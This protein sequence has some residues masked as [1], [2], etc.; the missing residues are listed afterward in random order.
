M[1]LKL[2]YIG[3]TT[4]NDLYENDIYGKGE[5]S[6]RY[7]KW[8]F[9]T[10]MKGWKNY[11][12]SCG[13]QVS[14]QYSSAAVATQSKVRTHGSDCCSLGMLK[15]RGSFPNTNQKKRK[16]PF[17]LQVLP[18]TSWNTVASRFST[19]HSAEIKTSCL[20]IV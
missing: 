11:F 3:H 5:K 20:C 13:Q 18:L 9:K 10:S 1:L 6:V 14:V 4:K 2:L 8:I 12:R 15:A 17:R 19:E 16:K 7:K